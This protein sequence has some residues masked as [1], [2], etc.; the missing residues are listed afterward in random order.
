MSVNILVHNMRVGAESQTRETKLHNLR[1]QNGAGV[2][3]FHLQK[4][5]LSPYGYLIR[6]GMHGTHRVKEQS[7]NFTYQIF[8]AIYETQTLSL[9]LNKR[10]LFQ[11]QT[12]PPSSQHLIKLQ[13]FIFP[14]ICMVHFTCVTLLYCQSK[15]LLH[16]ADLKF[17]RVEDRTRSLQHKETWRVSLFL[18][19]RTRNFR[20]PESLE[21]C[22][23]CSLNFH[24]LP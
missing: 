17:C 18:V 16:W 8:N 6:L 1:Q 7:Q 24:S 10:F 15:I 3:C 4:C 11:T 14:C 22:I 2:L 5:G 12:I 19:P 13:C 20:F 9:G 23:H 21:K